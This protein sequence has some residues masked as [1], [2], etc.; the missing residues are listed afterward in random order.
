MIDE[1]LE[2][3]RN[4]EII[5]LYDFDDREKE[6]DLVIAA[7]FVAPNHIC[8]LRR[9]GGGL[10]CLA[11]DPVACSNLGI[12]YIADVLKFASGSGNGFGAIESMYER[13]G[14]IP[15]DTKS[16]SLFGSTTGTTTQASQTSTVP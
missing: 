16:L 5:L 9:D 13:A 8:R 14:D 6:T 3:L 15:Y 1:A 10:I 7:E 12:P 4:G 2:A 11:I